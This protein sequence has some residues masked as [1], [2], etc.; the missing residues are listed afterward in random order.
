MF[1]HASQAPNIKVLTPSISNHGKPLIYFT[2]KRE[3]A[4]VYL[5]NAV[6]KY[7]NESGIKHQGVYKT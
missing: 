5:S 4:L 1:F 6:E 3:N 7:C 2:Q